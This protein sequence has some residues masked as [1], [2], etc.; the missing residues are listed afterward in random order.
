MI[1]R[2][3]RYL[4]GRPQEKG[5]DVDLA[6]NPVI[7]A[8]QGD[9]DIGAVMSPDNDLLP[10]LETVL[11]DGPSGCRVEVAAWGTKGQD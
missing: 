2:E 1:E 5:I 11:D 8:I 7:L 6:V 9:Y 10:A 3:L 4:Q